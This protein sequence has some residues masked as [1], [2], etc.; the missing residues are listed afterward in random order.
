V[1]ADAEDFNDM[2]NIGKKITAYI[3]SPRTTSK[4]VTSLQREL[5]YTRTF[6]EK[7]NK[8]QSY[9]FVQ[10][11]R[12]DPRYADPR[13]LIHSELAVFSQ[14]GEDGILAE[15]F[16]RIGTTSKTFL[17]FGVGTGMENNSAFLLWQDWSGAWIEGDPES[18]AKINQTFRKFLEKRQLKILQEFITAENIN[19][20]IGRLGLGG[21]MDF[22]CV[23]IDRNTYQVLEAITAIRPRVICA[24]YNSVFPAHIDWVVDYDGAKVWDRSNYFGA[25]LKAFERMCDAKGYNLVG[26]DITGVNAFFVRKDVCA[27][28]F[29]APFT[30]ENHY[31]PP[32]FFLYPMVGM[33]H[34]KSMHD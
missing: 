27:D 1:R 24:E 2:K 8:L 18:I 34:H 17:E 29:V 32:R 4:G 31:E 30:A 22:L 10:Q 12:A 19:K 3:K 6:L 20:L 13:R 28:H 21:E 16:R 15:I 5:A 23:D 26:C 14:N 25:S 33:H 7:A 9:Q 11:L